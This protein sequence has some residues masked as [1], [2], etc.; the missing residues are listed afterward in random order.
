[1]LGCGLTFAD[2]PCNGSA[3]ATKIPIERIEKSIYLIRG[4]KM[5]RDAD[6]A[7]LYSVTTGNL[8]KAVGRNKERF[9]PDFM[10]QLSDQE[11][12]DLVFQSG[13]SSQ[14]GGRRNPPFAFTEQGV[15]ML[16]SV[17]RS[18]RAIAVNIEVVRTFV[19]LRKMSATHT[20][21]ARRLDELEAT[22][23]QHIKLIWKT[24]ED[25]VAPDPPKNKGKLG[26]G[27]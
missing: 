13:T 24:I 17:L 12:R 26:F 2:R 7:K 21:L 14:W 18:K 22:H 11:F 1:M 23:S 5:M 3:V 9:P 6:L 19:S 15:A 10:I 4:E 16:S 20:R 25:L 8:N 27:R